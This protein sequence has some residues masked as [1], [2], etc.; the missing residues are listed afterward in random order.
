MKIKMLQHYCGYLNDN[1]DFWPNQEYTIPD[2]LT[3][4]AAQQLVERNYAVVIEESRTEQA[5][6]ETVDLMKA[7]RARK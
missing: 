7:R 3:E 1:R 5:S 6:L 2:D 4:E